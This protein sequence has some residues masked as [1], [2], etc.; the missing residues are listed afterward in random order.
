VWIGADRSA[1]DDLQRIRVHYGECV[2][3]LGKRQQGPPRRRLSNNSD[4]GGKECGQCGTGDKRLGIFGS[5]HSSPLSLV[6]DGA[7]IF[8]ISP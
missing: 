8:P 1:C 5:H 2:V 4:R 3:T 6:F 7:F